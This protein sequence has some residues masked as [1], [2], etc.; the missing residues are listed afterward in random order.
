MEQP[1]IK[2]LMQF[3]EQD[4]QELD[5]HIL[6]THIDN[7]NKAFIISQFEEIDKEGSFAEIYKFDEPIVYPGLTHYYLCDIGG[8]TPDGATS[9]EDAIEFLT[10]ITEE[11][12]GW[13]RDV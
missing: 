5:I 3:P 8:S 11:K 7:G 13:Y 10:I 9:I 6:K 2:I 4:P 1:K 12:V